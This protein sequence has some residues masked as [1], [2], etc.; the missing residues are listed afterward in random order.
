MTTIGN[1][2]ILETW[3]YQH[4]GAT[5]DNDTG[6]SR[7]PHGTPGPDHPAAQPPGNTG[8]PPPRVT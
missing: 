3:L 6:L 2:D 7:E 4:T 8:R 1:L 5:L